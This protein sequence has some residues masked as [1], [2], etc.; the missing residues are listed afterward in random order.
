VRLAVDAGLALGATRL[1]LDVGQLAQALG[2]RDLLA[3]VLGQVG[4][5]L[6]LRLGSGGVG[7]LLGAMRAFSVAA[8]CSACALRCAAAC[9]TW[10]FWAF[11]RASVS[12][13]M[14]SFSARSACAASC[15]PCVRV[16][17]ACLRCWAAC[18]FSAF[19]FCSASA[20]R[21]SAFCSRATAV[22]STSER[23][24]SALPRLVR[25]SSSSR[26]PAFSSTVPR[27]FS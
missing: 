17:S 2:L 14:R 18:C 3:G 21:A 24:R 6:E 16:C 1:G 13:R 26:R 22:A 9:S 27:A 20:L 15:R 19:S 8:A 7:L 10:S 25:P 23:R 11:S 5:L 4:G 12:R